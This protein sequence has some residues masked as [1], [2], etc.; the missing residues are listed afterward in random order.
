VPPG[1]RRRGGSAPRCCRPRHPR[2]RA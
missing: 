2:N 1:P